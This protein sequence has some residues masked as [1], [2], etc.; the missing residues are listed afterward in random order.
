MRLL[1]STAWLPTLHAWYALG[2]LKRTL[3]S[4]TLSYLATATVAAAA[5]IVPTVAPRTADNMS[6][7][8]NYEI[9]SNNNDDNNDDD[10][11]NNNNNNNNAH[12]P[13]PRGALQVAAR[14]QH[15]PVVVAHLEHE[16]Q[17]FN[18]VGRGAVNSWW[19]YVAASARAKLPDLKGS[20]GCFKLAAS[21]AFAVASALVL[22]RR[23]AEQEFGAQDGLRRLQ[24][25]IHTQNSRLQYQECGCTQHTQACC[26]RP[27]A[28]TLARTHTHTRQAPT[29][30][31]NQDNNTNNNNK[32][33]RG[34][35]S[36]LH[37]TTTRT[38]TTTPV[39]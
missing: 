17:Q 5:T 19:E 7:N 36:L 14:G 2:V 37:E 3:A 23:L 32:G 21:G 9:N 18:L 25:Q 10:N 6:S 38:S 8:S 26:R 29:K 20:G 16:L 22:D 27:H 39:K 31:E 24:K 13:G 15:Y 4:A 35:T 11:N 30:I 12:Y 1:S 34:P 33:K 28:R